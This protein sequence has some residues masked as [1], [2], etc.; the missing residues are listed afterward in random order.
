MI[1]RLRVVVIGSVFMQANVGKIVTRDEIENGKW[2]M[3]R[4]KIRN[5]LYICTFNGAWRSWLA[6]L[7]GVQGVG[8]SSL[9]APTD[10]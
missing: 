8:S 10:E 9:L 7:H 3:E 6:Y 5:I 4:I 1:N 2:K